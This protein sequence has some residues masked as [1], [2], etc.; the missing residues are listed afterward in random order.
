MNENTSRPPISFWSIVAVL[1][2]FT[3]FY[4]STFSP[5]VLMLPVLYLASFL[6][7]YRFERDA[8]NIWGLRLLIY[9]GF[10]VLGRTPTGM[11]GYFVDAQAFT[12]AGLIAGGELVLQSFRKPPLGARF[13][14]LIVTL[15][16]V[17]FLI[18]SN[19]FRDHVWLL[20][21]LYMASVLFSLADL[22]PGANSSK[23]LSSG[24]RAGVI[25]VAVV[26]GASLHQALWA[27]RGS[28]MSLGA[29]LLS[30]QINAAQTA[31]VSDN[32]LLTSS[33][34]QGS[35]TARLL[36]IQGTLDDPHLRAASFDTYT[37]GG[38]GPAIS[39]R[40]SL[41]K[42]LPPALPK[43][44][45][46][47]NQ[48][49]ET[50]P[51]SQANAKITLLRDSGGVLFA[52]LNSWAIM[53]DIGQ[54]FNWD[55]YQ[56]PFATEEPPPVS[57]YVI[58]SRVEKYDFQMEQ[59][60]LCVAPTRE[61][62]E[63]LLVVPPEIDRRVVFLAKEITQDGK[64]QV[65]KASMIVDY[66]FRTN[67]YSLTYERGPGDPISD[68]V[69]NKRAAH[70]QYFAS[71]A[72]MMM[73]AVGIP[74]RYATGYFAHESAEDGST[75]V[76]GR[77]AH[78]WAEAY[79]DNVGWVTL[80]ATPSGGRADP[81]VSPSPWYEKWL[82]KAQ[83]NFAR[84]R[85][86]FGNLTQMQIVGIILVI[87]VFWG[88]ER[89]RQARK[90]ARKAIAALGIP[91]EFAPLARRFERLL[92]KRGVK[93][94]PERP[95]SEAIPEEMQQEREWI[96]EYNRARFDRDSHIETEE[97]ERELQKLEK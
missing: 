54:S 17:I 92:S 47:E 58:N 37:N 82:E 81:A 14:P 69:L 10:A 1:T 72:A 28:I 73:R 48:K 9:A 35:S 68:F 45:R 11:P 57:Y 36:R 39:S 49:G 97:L 56:G 74:A 80:D 5:F 59:G 52:P 31:G 16:G 86:W 30:N 70:C 6:L 53:P 60:P 66:L 44:T 23:P 78:A 93:P 15:S 33:F 22:R 25:I 13:E 89:W 94:A 90:K 64:T 62:R 55:R 7:P 21:P 88:L 29:R 43:D 19:S 50:R 40:F 71:A 18:A 84:V 65:E 12:T 96:D 8:A 95:W 32:P 2:A 26:L 34:A 42:P 63:R 24:L 87:L 77:D 38:W 51:R 83:D 4:L 61:Q 27:N 85:A 20:A 46:E 41:T 76:R 91:P 75:I 79:F 67:P 3:T